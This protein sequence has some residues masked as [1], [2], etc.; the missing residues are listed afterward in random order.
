MITTFHNEFVQ[1]FDAVQFCF[2]I[3]S[4]V[5]IET[6]FTKYFAN[7]QMNDAFIPQALH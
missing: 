7:V 2:I 3:L 6:I 5:Y 4:R 1:R